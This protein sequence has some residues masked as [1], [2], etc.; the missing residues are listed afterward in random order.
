[1]GA[2]PVQFSAGYHARIA[3][4]A[5]ALS[6]AGT[7]QLLDSTCA[8]VTEQDIL[9]LREVDDQDAAEVLDRHIC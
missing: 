5:L 6:G 4:K 1:V 3:M 9:N 2:Q 7:V 8:E